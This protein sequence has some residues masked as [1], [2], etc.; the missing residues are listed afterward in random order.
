MTPAAQ[1]VRSPREKAESHSRSVL[2]QPAESRNIRRLFSRRRRRSTFRGSALEMSTSALSSSFR[3]RRL[4]G[5]QP[6]L[7]VDGNDGQA[8]GATA[9]A[10]LTLRQYSRSGNLKSQILSHNY[11]FLPNLQVYNCEMLAAYCFLYFQGSSVH[12]A[13]C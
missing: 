3:D 5:S 12:L 11:F 2:P 6:S 8:D 13:T 9:A 1:Q 4:G 10:L 7:G